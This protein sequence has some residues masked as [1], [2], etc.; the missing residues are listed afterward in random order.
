MM[1]TVKEAAARAGVGAALVYG[2]CRLGVLPH[3]R[4]GAA[5]KRGAIRIDSDD[6]RRKLL[7]P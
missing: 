3:Y 4:L 6:K 5:G 7:K 1:L 2:W